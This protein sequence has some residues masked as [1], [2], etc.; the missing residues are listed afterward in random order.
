[1]VA[2]LLVSSF[3]ALGE[4]V[5]RDV[6]L[7]ELAPVAGGLLVTPFARGEDLLV[8]SD[9]LFWKVRDLGITMSTELVVL[10]VVEVR[11]EV[12][13]SMAWGHVDFRLLFSSKLKVRWG[14]DPL[15][16]F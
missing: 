7:R 6:A 10:R 15:I 1:M 5:L 11:R 2:L 13:E 16:S 9:M 8:G 14:D 4:V 3:R 12:L